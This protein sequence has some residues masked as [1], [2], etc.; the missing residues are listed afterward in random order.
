MPD[1]DKDVVSYQQA[2]LGIATALP[3]VYKDWPVGY[4]PNLTVHNSVP[5][6]TVGDA[7]GNVMLMKMHA[8]AL[9]YSKPSRY[10]PT[11]AG[12]H[13]FD[14]NIRRILKE[15][16]GNN[17]TPDAL[18]F[19]LMFDLCHELFH[20]V[21]IQRSYARIFQSYER[22][23]D[24]YFSAELTTKQLEHILGSAR[25]EQLTERLAMNTMLAWWFDRRGMSI[26]TLYNGEMFVPRVDS[27]FYENLRNVAYA[28]RHDHLSRIT[29]EA[30]TIMKLHYHMYHRAWDKDADSRRHHGKLCNELFECIED[31][32]KE[33]HAKLGKSYILI[34]ED[35]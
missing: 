31:S 33:C 2:Y 26:D 34:N 25:E 12:I 35:V 15:N 3:T 5:E 14:T 19:E 16:Y 9:T 17:I 28:K 10:C 21:S 24:S 30:L 11:N 7:R 27:A 22:I 32:A 18:R 6:N 20:F 23:E 4:P 1:N 8:E 29:Y 13:V